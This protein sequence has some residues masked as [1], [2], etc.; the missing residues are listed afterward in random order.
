MRRLLYTIADHSGELPPANFQ[1][2]KATAGDET[3][4]QSSASNG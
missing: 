3:L 4:R 2:P 1:I